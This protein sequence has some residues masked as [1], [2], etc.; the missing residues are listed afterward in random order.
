[1]QPC[2]IAAYAE[3]NSGVIVNMAGGGYDQP[4][5]GGSGYAVSK[6]GLMR[7]TDTLAFE[8][9]AQGGRVRLGG[10]ERVRERELLSKIESHFFRFFDDRHQETGRAGIARHAQ[11]KHHPNL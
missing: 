10:K 5:V 3:D 7:L 1:M 11:I 4:N 9:G 2:G 6:A 8:L